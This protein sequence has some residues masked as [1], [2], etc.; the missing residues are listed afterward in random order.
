M[1]WGPLL[2]GFLF[3]VLCLFDL[4]INVVMNAVHV[5]DPDGHVVFAKVFLRPH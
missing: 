5:E 4:L 2:E 1:D 3:R